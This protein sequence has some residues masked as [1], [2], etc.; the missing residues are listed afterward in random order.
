LD[1]RNA[2]VG[3]SGAGELVEEQ[4]GFLTKI[5]PHHSRLNAHLLRADTKMLLQ[6]RRSQ[7]KSLK[8]GSW[9]EVR[10][11]ERQLGKGRAQRML[12]GAFFCTACFGDMLAV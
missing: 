9:S 11:M 3:G 7:R 12:Q 1:S 4:G 2:S 5:L 6:A 10:R 8:S